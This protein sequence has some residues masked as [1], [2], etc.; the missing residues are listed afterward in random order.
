MTSDC[1][2]DADVFVNH[3]FTATAAEAVAAVLRAGTDVDCGTFVS[4]NAPEALQRGLITEADIDARLANL[5]RVR[6]RLGHFDAAAGPLDGIP[7]EVICSAETRATA[8]AGAAQGYRKYSKD[9]KIT[10]PWV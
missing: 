2:A 9:Q 7:T 10:D 8:E 3:N 4:Q 5:L 1:D 6:L